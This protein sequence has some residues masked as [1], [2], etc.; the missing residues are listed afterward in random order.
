[1]KYVKQT[2]VCVCAYAYICKESPSLKGLKTQLN[3]INLL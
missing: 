3:L 1:M 2:F